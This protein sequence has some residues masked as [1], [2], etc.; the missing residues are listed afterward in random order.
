MVLIMVMAVI[1]GGAKIAHDHSYVATIFS[2]NSAE[3]DNTVCR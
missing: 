3:A 2:A 1:T